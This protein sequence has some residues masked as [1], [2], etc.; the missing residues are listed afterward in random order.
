MTN[1]SGLKYKIKL[2]NQLIKPI[3]PLKTNNTHKY[4]KNIYPIN[5]KY[6]ILD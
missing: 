6:Y 1:P 2:I 3:E 4:V 5:M